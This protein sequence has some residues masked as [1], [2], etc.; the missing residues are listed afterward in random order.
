MLLPSIK[1]RV[2]ESFDRAAITYDAAAVVQRCVCDRLLEELDPT[3]PAPIGLL[4]A[5]CGTGYGARLLRKRWPDTRITG[6]DF[7]PSM[8]SLAQRETDACFTAD[9]EKLPFADE[10]FDLW[11]SSLTIQWCDNDTVFSEAARVLRPNGRL[12]VSTLGPNTFHELREAFSG[13]DQHRHTLPFSEPDAVSA[14]LARSGLRNIRLRREKHSVHYPN[15]K[16]L[17]RSVKDIGAHNV[18][19]G[20]RNGMMGRHAWQS[21]EAAYEQHREAAGLPA[22]YDVILAYAQK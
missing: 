10:N 18:G 15:L 13:V 20:A 1:Q 7:A 6:V 16:T 12:A 14:S 9:I 3:M 21:V 4:D 2:R 17:L 22:S 8:A 5:G 19:E 11:W